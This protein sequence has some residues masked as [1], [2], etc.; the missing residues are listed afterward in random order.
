M[1]VSTHLPLPGLLY[2]ST[3][4]AGFTSGLVAYGVTQNLEGARGY[5]SWQWLFIIEGVSTL[6]LGL[7]VLVILP[8]FPDRI[9]RKG[10]FLFRNSSEQEMM[11]ARQ[12]TGQLFPW[13]YILHGAEQ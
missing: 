9:A 11:L 8:S 10:H 2:C 4:V 13:A 5:A 3:P 12:V 1:S 7:V 6:A